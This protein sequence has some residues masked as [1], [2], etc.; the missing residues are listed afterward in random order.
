LRF[1]LS[2]STDDPTDGNAQQQQGYLEGFG[3][4]DAAKPNA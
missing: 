1:A 3:A 2:E 4:S